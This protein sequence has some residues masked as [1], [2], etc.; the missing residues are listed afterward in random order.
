MSTLTPEEQSKYFLHSLQ[1]CWTSCNSYKN[2]H[3]KRNI[4]S[5]KE[6]V[7]VKTC[8]VKVIEGLD[9]IKAM[10]QGIFRE[11]AG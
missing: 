8:V 5:E 9:I 4:L 6:E 7:C 11:T 1:S 10:P 3:H 2:T